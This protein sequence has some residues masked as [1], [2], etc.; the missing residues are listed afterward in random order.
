MAQGNMNLCQIVGWKYMNPLQSN[1]AQRASVHV[2]ARSGLTRPLDQRHGLRWNL[3]NHRMPQ[4]RT[5]GLR[6]IVSVGRSLRTRKF[7]PV[8]RSC[9]VR[10]GDLEPRRISVMWWSG[11]RDW[12]KAI[13]EDEWGAGN[14][15]PGQ[16]RG[17]TFFRLRE[18][19][20]V[21]AS[22]SGVPRLQQDVI[23]R[24]PP[25]VEQPLPWTPP[26]QVGVSSSS[27]RRGQVTAP[28]RGRLAMESIQANRPIL[29]RWHQGCLELRWPRKGAGPSGSA[30]VTGSVSSSAGIPKA[31][32][33]GATGLVPKAAWVAGRPTSSFASSSSSMAVNHEEGYAVDS[34]PSTLE[35]PYRNSAFPKGSTV[36]MRPTPRPNRWADGPTISIREGETS[37]TAMLRALQASHP[38]ILRP[39]TRPVDE[40]RLAR[41]TRFQTSMRSDVSDQ[42]LWDFLHG[43]CPDT[44][45][46]EIPGDDGEDYYEEAVGSES[47]IS[48]GSFSQ[49]TALKTN[50]PM[51]GDM[52]SW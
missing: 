12:T 36:L 40:T 45:V 31:G 11:D 44:P 16:W 48:D 25:E 41:R 10:I 23:Q 49:V 19:P 38:P 3:I 43:V 37:Q 24:N 30:G 27:L 22:S 1:V 34:T 52:W 32:Y 17:W 6:W 13:Q 28:E 51:R 46:P 5:S 4:I 47:E 39:S 2:S 50:R 15:E 8:H 21:G 20:Q 7:H 29:V 35:S 26:T 33:F 18:S 14:V 42:D 9:P